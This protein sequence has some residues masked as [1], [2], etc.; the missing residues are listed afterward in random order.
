MY[1][2]GL[3]V[4]WCGHTDVV[5]L[6]CYLFVYTLSKNLW[7]LCAYI[8]G[9]YAP[10]WGPFVSCGYS[11]ICTVGYNTLY[12]VLAKK[13]IWGVFYKMLM[14]KPDELPANPILGGAVCMEYA[15]GLWVV[16]TD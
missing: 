6:G 14:E 16:S 7:V 2:W 11:D 13:F 1:T 9:I 15:W 8:I 5:I 4:L 10:I 12:I 3:G